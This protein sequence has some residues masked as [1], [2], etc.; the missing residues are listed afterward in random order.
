MLLVLVERRRNVAAPLSALIADQRDPLHLAH[1]CRCAAS[2][3]VGDRAVCRANAVAD[4]FGLRGCNWTLIGQ[5]KEARDEV[6]IS[7]DTVRRRPDHGGARLRRL[8]P[9]AGG[10]A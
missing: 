4:R 2:P 3:Y 7:K 9:A 5:P 10:E 6:A 8:G 1:G